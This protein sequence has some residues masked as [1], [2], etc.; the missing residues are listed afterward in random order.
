MKDKRDVRYDVGSNPSPAYPGGG[1]WLP[2]KE[3]GNSTPQL[4]HPETTFLRHQA[5]PVTYF[6]EPIEAPIPLCPLYNGPQCCQ[7]SEDTLYQGTGDWAGCIPQTYCNLSPFLCQVTLD[8]SQG[9]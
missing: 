6:L 2:I 4:C 5:G 9:S 3:L 1:A 7:A 8:V